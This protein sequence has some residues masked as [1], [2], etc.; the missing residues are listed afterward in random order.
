MRQ[1]WKSGVPWSRQGDDW[2][3]RSRRDEGA[4]W[5]WWNDGP[6]WLRGSQ[7]PKWSRWIGRPRWSPGL[8]GGDWGSSNPEV[9]G[10]RKSRSTTDP[11]DMACW[12]WAEGLSWGSRDRADGLAGWYRGGGSG[13]LGGNLLEIF[14]EELAEEEVLGGTNRGSGELDGTSRGSGEL[15]GTSRKGRSQNS[16]FKQS[17]SSESS[18]S[19]PS[20][21]GVWAGLS[22]IPSI[23][24]IIPM[25]H[26]VAGS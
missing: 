3:R 21:V 26:S 2:P 1:S 4:R 9:A 12:G 5:S 15:N 11:P 20:V 7:E 19:S 8:E 13:S 17:N 18:N 14:V 24:T 10:D 23:S 25:M 22:S 16:S 6:R